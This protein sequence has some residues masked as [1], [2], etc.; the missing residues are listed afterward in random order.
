MSISS[1]NLD[2]PR[3]AGCYSAWAEVAVVIDHAP[4]NLRRAHLGGPFDRHI[5]TLNFLA[6]GLHDLAIPINVLEDRGHGLS[7][8]LLNHGYRLGAHIATNV[9]DLLNVGAA[10]AIRR[11]GGNLWR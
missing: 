1:T 2:S 7:H 8:T 9:E 6:N 3:S 4:A 10:T 5:H 11:A